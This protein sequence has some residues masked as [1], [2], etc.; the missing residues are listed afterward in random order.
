MTLRKKDMCTLEVRVS[1]LVLQSQIGPLRRISRL[2]M[3]KTPWESR[4]MHP[5]GSEATLVLVLGQKSKWTNGRVSDDAASGTSSRPGSLRPAK[6]SGLRSTS[7]Q[8]TGESEKPEAVMTNS[9][10][11]N[12]GI[13]W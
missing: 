8:S 5:T 3:A 9:S 12:C 13:A 7:S 1:K 11:L 6:K 2:E 4:A 10:A